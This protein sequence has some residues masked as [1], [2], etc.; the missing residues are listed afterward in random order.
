MEGSKDDTTTPPVSRLI[1]APA[2]VIGSPP[3]VTNVFPMLAPAEF[4]VKVALPT[5]NVRD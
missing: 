2:V 5:V 4:A 1:T 3:G